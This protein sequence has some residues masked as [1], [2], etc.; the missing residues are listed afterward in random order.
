MLPGD[1]WGDRDAVLADHH[2]DVPE[3][4]ETGE[5]AAKSPPRAREEGLRHYI[6]IACIIFLLSRLFLLVLL[7][8]ENSQCGAT[9][10]FR[11]YFALAV[12]FFLLVLRSP[13][14]IYR[15]SFR[16][17]AASDSEAVSRR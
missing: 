5:Q 1:R 15:K 7:R 8:G 17:E 16:S 11:M 10:G 13:L 14:H 4:F 3:L 6:N 2:D 9:D 12:M